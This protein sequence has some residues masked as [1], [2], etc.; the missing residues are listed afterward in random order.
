MFVRGQ[1]QSEHERVALLQLNAGP[2]IRLGSGVVGW[3]RQL[4]LCISRTS[5]DYSVQAPVDKY[6]TMP[7]ISMQGFSTLQAI[8][9]GFLPA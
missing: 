9:R 1:V 8:W 2:T 6:L 5:V 3:K 7:A 4:A